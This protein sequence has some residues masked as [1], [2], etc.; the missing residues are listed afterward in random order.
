[1][2]LKTSTLFWTFLWCWFMGI[3]AISIGFGALFPS[4][5][6]I[7]KPLVCPDGKMDLQKQVYNPYPGET[8]TTL[9]WYCVDESAGTKTELGI[10]PMSLYAGTI[11]G[12]LLFGVVLV[13]MV[14]AANRRQGQPLDDFVITP[15]KLKSSEDTLS[16]MKELKDLR[17][18]NLISETEYEDKRSEILKSL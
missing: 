14:L 8:V 10:F 7:A 16:R 6:R 1:M 5:N 17:A 11:Y 13:G 2:K 9:T 4:M 18:A 15:D 3:T 12:L